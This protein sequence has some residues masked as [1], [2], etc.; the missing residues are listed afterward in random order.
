MCWTNSLYKVRNERTVGADAS[1]ERCAERLWL[2]H[3]PDD[4]AAQ[5]AA[6]LRAAFAR[7]VSGSDLVLCVYAASSDWL[8]HSRSFST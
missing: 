4:M 7:A 8:L 5:L 3:H 2:V 6:P 1:V